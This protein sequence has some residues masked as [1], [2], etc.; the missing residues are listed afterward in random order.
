MNIEN[1]T[2]YQRKFM[3]MFLKF[4]TPIMIDKNKYTTMMNI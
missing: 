4:M 2:K 1:K 3:F